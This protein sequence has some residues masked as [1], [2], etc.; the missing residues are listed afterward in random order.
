KSDNVTKWPPSIIRRGVV[1]IWTAQESPLPD[2]SRSSPERSQLCMVRTWSSEQEGSP[3]VSPDENGGGA[4]EGGY[5]NP[6][7]SHRRSSQS[8]PDRAPRSRA[9]KSSS[10]RALASSVPPTRLQAGLKSSRV[11]PKARESPL[12]SRVCAHHACTSSG[13]STL[14]FGFCG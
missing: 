7:T 14:W 6:K 8:A 10:H 1:A 12:K 4:P 9:A 11:R 13:L 5:R 3:G 2:V